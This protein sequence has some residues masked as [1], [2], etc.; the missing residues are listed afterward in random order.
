VD[1]THLIDHARSHLERHYR[2]PL[3]DRLVRGLLA[4]TLPYPKRFRMALSIAS[5]FKSAAPLLPR[6]L[7]A[8]LRLAPR[9]LPRIPPDLFQ[10]RHGNVTGSRR[11]ALLLGCAHRAIAP[12]VIAATIR[13]LG[14]H[15]CEISVVPEIECCGSLSLH[16]GREEQA[17]SF[18]RKAVDHWCRELDRGVTAIVVNAAGCG[19][20]VK[21]YGHLLTGEPHYA[22]R[23]ARVAAAARD[24]AE[25]IDSVGLAAPAQPS[26]I[27][28][29]YH[30]ACSLRNGQRITAAPRRLLRAAGFVVRDVPE[31]QLCC[32]SAGTYNL[33][34]PDIASALGRRKADHVASTTASILAVGNLGCIMQLK[35]FLAIPIVHTVELLDW[36]TGGPRPASLAGLTLPVCRQHTGENDRSGSGSGPPNGDALIW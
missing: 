17:K 1:Y 18:A 7:R 16:L 24:I 21:D 3:T 29:A 12:D 33:L 34:Q 35:Q 26:R 9:R 13:L 22:E 5:I 2:R 27:A 10:G 23:A 31:A 4:R 19:T 28:V 8:M 15:G 32:G 36:G 14:R 25:Y 30:D 20:T 11:V 6:R